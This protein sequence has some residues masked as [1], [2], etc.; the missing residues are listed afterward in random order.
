[1]T[2][3]N[4]EKLQAEYRAGRSALERGQYRTSV[5]H[6]EAA[7]KL[8]A[9]GSRI[10]G[11][12][13]MWLV[14][15]YQ[16]AGQQNQ[17]LALCQKLTVYPHSEIRK[18][19]KQL[20]YIMEA[21]QLNRPKEWMVEIPDLSTLEISDPKDRRGSNPARSQST[22][23]QEDAFDLPSGETKDNQFI[24]VALLALLLAL[25]SLIWLS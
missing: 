8:A 10:G 19:S 2:L 24:W 6:L 13:Q 25:G 11:E 22:Q 18:Q 17:A 15:A 1:M 16:A 23:I 12:V 20:L 5:Q 3:E 21:P 4:Q 14:S 9:P 7:S